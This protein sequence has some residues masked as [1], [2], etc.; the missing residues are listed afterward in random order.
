MCINV[1]I[2]KNE[3]HESKRQQQCE[4]GQDAETNTESSEIHSVLFDF[5]RKME[6]ICR[7]DD[8]CAFMKNIRTWQKLHT[9][10]LLL[11]IGKFYKQRTVY[12]M[13][14]SD[15]SLSFW[16]TVAIKTV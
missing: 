5:I 7:L 13:R 6:D 3:V 11:D 9:M 8:F 12:Y 1:E 16:V 10:H 2:K 4:F 14:Y 15:V